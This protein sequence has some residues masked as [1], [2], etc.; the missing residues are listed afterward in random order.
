M[1]EKRPPTGGQ[2]SLGRSCFRSQA[3]AYVGSAEAGVG[4]REGKAHPEKSARGGTQTQPRRE[5]YQGFLWCLSGKESTCQCRRRRFDP[6][7]RKTPWRRKWQTPLVFFV[8]E[9]PWTEKLGEP[10]SPC[11]SQKSQTRLSNEIPTTHYQTLV[12]FL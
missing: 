10:H 9:I 8:W 6:W 5:A 1:A 2:G 7:V 12:R 11:G 4:V 3:R